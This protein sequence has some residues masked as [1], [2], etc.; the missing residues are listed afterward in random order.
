MEVKCEVCE[1]PIPKMRLQALPNT[2]FCV[3][4]VDK[5]APKVVHNPDD[6]CARASD[7]ARNGFAADD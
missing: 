3:K 6:I 4:C 2:T 5:H 7:S 1:K